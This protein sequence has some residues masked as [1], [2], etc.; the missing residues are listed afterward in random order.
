MDEGGEKMN[1]ER[2][3]GGGR[4]RRW[5]REGEERKREGEEREGKGR[6]E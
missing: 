6:R 4:S 5:A 2:G 3:E 1:G